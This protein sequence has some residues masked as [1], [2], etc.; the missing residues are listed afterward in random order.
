MSLFFVPSMVG[1]VNIQMNSSLN[2]E[3]SGP[4]KHW[5]LSTTTQY[6]ILG[7]LNPSSYTVLLFSS[8]NWKSHCNLPKNLD[9]RFET[10]AAMSRRSSLSSDFCSI[11]RYLATEERRTN[12]CGWVVVYSC[13]HI[14]LSIEF[15]Q[16][17]F[18]VKLLLLANKKECRRH[19]RLVFF[20]SLDSPVCCKIVR[21]KVLLTVNIN[22]VGL[23]DVTAWDRGSMI[24]W[25]FDNSSVDFIPSHPRK[26][27][28]FPLSSSPFFFFSILC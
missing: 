22:T 9:G 4:L 13:M 28:F 2:I 18:W 14:Y 27:L 16:F 23:W 3:A 11:D 6:H 5:H 20:G 7:V 17:I 1:A 12:L 8:M 15:H 21:F 25:N 24:L 10:S 26:S 19:T